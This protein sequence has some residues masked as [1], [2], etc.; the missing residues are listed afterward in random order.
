MQ[1]WSD[2]WSRARESAA[3]WRNV[4][5]GSW[6]WS[7]IKEKKLKIASQEGV[8]LRSKWEGSHLRTFCVEEKR[9]RFWLRA[10]VVESSE[11][12]KE[13]AEGDMLSIW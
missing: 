2:E 8:K 12:R 7:R 1:V 3:E 4:A 13:T 10:A 9:A 6:T 5:E 11:D